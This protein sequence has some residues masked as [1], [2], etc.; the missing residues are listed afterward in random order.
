MD[1]FG[2]ATTGLSMIREGCRILHGLAT[3]DRAI[4][5]TRKELKRYYK[6]LAT[7]LKNLRAVYGECSQGVLERELASCKK[8]LTNF[9]YKYGNG[10]LGHVRYSLSSDRGNSV[11]EQFRRSEIQLRLEID[12]L[13]L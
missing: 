10:L 7:L 5:Q 12:S 6:R 2:T 1:I 4:R 3:A 11:R 13:E 8:S 9:L